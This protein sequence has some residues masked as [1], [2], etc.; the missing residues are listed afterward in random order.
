[1]KEIVLVIQLI[2]AAAVGLLVLYLTGNVRVASLSA[3]VYLFG[4]GTG[5]LIRWIRGAR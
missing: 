3:S 5:L 1:V 4:I 2:F